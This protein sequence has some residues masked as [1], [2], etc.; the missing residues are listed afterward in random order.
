MSVR[1]VR[2][3]EDV[4]HHHFAFYFS[5]GSRWLN[6]P[7][8]HG[9]V[10]FLD[11]SW[12]LEAKVRDRPM[13]SFAFPETA[14]AVLLSWTAEWV[15]E[16][17][18]VNIQ[19][20]LRDRGDALVYTDWFLDVRIPPARDSYEWKDEHELAEAVARGFLTEAESEDVRWAG[21]R[22]IEHVLLHEPPFDEDWPSWRPDPTWGPLDVPPDALGPNTSHPTP[23]EGEA[24]DARRPFREGGSIM[25]N[26]GGFTTPPPPPPPPGGEGGAGGSGLPPR[27]IGEILTT[28][29]DIYKAN[30]ANLLLIVAIVVVPLTFISAFLSGVVFAP[31][32]TTEV[33][34][35]QEIEV[36]SQS[37]G[38]ALLVGVIAAVIGVI[39]SAVLQAA[40][41]R[42]AAQGSIG[43]EVDIDASYKWGFAR[44]GSVLL[45]SILVGLAVMVG[46]LLFII[47]GIFLAVMFSVAIPALVVENLRGTDAMGRSWNLVKGNFWHALGLII[48]AFIL[49]AV[50]GGIIGAIGGAISDNWFVTWIFS[51]IA[52]I[53]VAPFT[54]LVSV[55]LYLDLRARTEALTSDG[56]RAQLNRAV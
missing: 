22:A 49:A 16:G 14:Y 33:V 26:S 6:D 9:E 38:A 8:D 41:M 15:F 4:P 30:A 12:E 55:L 29:F 51:S 37:A 56:L 43:D 35:G 5:P 47:P 40:I 19:S 34:F 48:V 42:G 23:R 1:P 21:E 10:R 45:I 25:D 53:I 3:V 17:Y 11:A 27:G 18:Y 7:R 20:P 52:Q 28:A 54:A 50:V 36:T 2:V 39:I 13:L 32:T 31:E 44:F 24:Y 46:L